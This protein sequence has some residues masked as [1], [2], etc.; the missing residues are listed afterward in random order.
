MSARVLKNKPL[1]ASVAQAT[2]PTSGT[3]MADTGAVTAAGLYEF[4]IFPG[5]SATAEFA[6]QRRNA[7]NGA[8]VGD[9]VVLYAAA[10]Q[11]GGYILTYSLE[12]GERVRVVM[13]EAVTGSAAVAINGERLG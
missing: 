11:T 6:V 9:V 2:D 8:N 3:V 10:G 7:A 4:R 13:N 5:A 12:V 1:L